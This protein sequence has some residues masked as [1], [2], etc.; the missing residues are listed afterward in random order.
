[1]KNIENLFSKRSSTQI[2]K[3][4][5][6]EILPCKGTWFSFTLIIVLI[7]VPSCVIGFSDKTIEFFIA[8]VEILNNIILALFAVVFTGYAFFQAL[9]NKE[10]LVRLLSNTNGKKSKLQE[11]NEYFANVMMLDVFAII[12]NAFLLITFK[13]IPNEFCLFSEN[14]INN[15]LAIL[16]IWIYFS[17]MF[18]II[19]EM[20][21]FVYNAFQLFNAHAGAKAIT[22]LKDEKE[23]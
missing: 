17:L 8:S 14:W 9:I 20:K 23:E 11:S 12:S 10:F 15:I 5:F 4:A 18:L 7:G 1:M 3:S 16:L 19:W 2:F 6:K 21:S 13:S 22:L